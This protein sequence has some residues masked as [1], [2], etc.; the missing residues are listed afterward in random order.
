MFSTSENQ[1]SKTR[2]LVSEKYPVLLSSFLE[3]RRARGD[4]SETAYR[5]FSPD[6]AELV[7][8][9]RFSPDPTGEAAL[10]MVPGLV[11]SY[12]NRCALLVTTSC[13]VY[14]R[15]CFRKTIV[16]QSAFEQND[17]RI[18]AAL[19]FIESSPEIRD[20]LLTG[21]DPAAASEKILSRIIEVLDGF[22]HIRS[23]RFHTRGLTAAPTLFVNRLTNVLTL[24]KKIWL[25]AHINHPD[26]INCQEARQAIESLQRQGI[27]ILSQTVLLRGV[28]DDTNTLRNLFLT[29]ND[30]RIIAYHLYLLDRVQ[31]AA[32]FDLEDGRIKELYMDLQE[33]PGTAFPTLVF[34]DKN[35]IKHRC[36]A[37]S[38][39]EL[40]AFLDLRRQFT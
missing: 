5:Q 3:Q 26:D 33:L 8:D 14:C 20:V 23:I 21:G 28:N 38:E 9:A 17:D 29:C 22:P 12:G 32:H 39:D 25:F 16:G 15:F 31:G 24:S 11:R 6:I 30:L 2:L 18:Q 27:P 13:L 4:Y 10:Q 37:A 36:V 1:D 35:S 40:Q 34:I 19:T 7:P